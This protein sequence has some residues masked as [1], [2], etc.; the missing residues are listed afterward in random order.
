MRRICDTYEG[1]RQDLGKT[2]PTMMNAH[3]FERKVEMEV[4]KEV[5]NCSAVLKFE[6][7]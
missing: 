2:C 4:G 1:N 6:T 5:F 7:D 3:P